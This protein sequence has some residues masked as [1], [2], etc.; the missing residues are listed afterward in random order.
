M[1]PCN[2]CDNGKCGSCVAQ[3][4][5]TK[6]YIRNAADHCGCAENGHSNDEVLDERPKVKSMLSKNQKEE[7]PKEKEIVE[8]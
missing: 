6:G 4:L 7:E 2:A 8:E 5:Q 1:T 3:A